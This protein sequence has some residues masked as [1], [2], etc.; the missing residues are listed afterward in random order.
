MAAL[1]IYEH[2]HRD[3]I[4]RADRIGIAGNPVDK[5]CEGTISCA[6]QAVDGGDHALAL[7]ETPRLVRVPLR[8]CGPLGPT[9]RRT[10]G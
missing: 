4:V 3:H 5:A 8:V 6:E 9:H 7:D 1:Q 2:M 10:E